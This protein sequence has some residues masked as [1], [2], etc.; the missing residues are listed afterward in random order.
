MNF[1]YIAITIII[2][3]ILYYL[4]TMKNGG[5]K[6]ISS[7]LYSGV[8][9]YGR[10]QAVIGVIVGVIVSVI[11][12]S[13]GI[14]RLH[15]PHTSSANM[16]ITDAVCGQSTTTD[17]NG[18]TI[19]NYTCTISV[20]FIASN[21]KRYTAQSVEVSSPTPLKIGM[22]INLRYNPANPSSVVQEMSPK[23]L[24]WGLIGGGVLV[25]AIA[26]GIAYLSFR[27]KGFAAVEGTASIASSIFNN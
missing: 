9:M 4:F 25:S 6:G 18:N 24:G 12:I 17:K 16:S 5:G 3:S 1:K 14:S 15:D 13:L 23:A 2:L 22:T 8:A 26:I 21:G 19:I 11:L 7:G 10:F 27:S 20:V